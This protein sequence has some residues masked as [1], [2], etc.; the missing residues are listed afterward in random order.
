MSDSFHNAIAGTIHSATG[1]EAQIVNSRSVSGGC[2]SS[3]EIVTLG[4]GRTFFVKSKL[5]A[6]ELF[7]RES[8]G[9][10][11]IERTNA[12]KVPA[13]IGL[14]ETESRVGFLVLEHIEGGGEGKG[15]S[16]TFGRQLAAMHRFNS[17]HGSGPDSFGFEADNFIGSTPQP[18]DWYADWGEFWVENRI[19]FQLK[20]AVEN[21]YASSEFRNGCENLIDKFDQIVAR[22]EC[23]CLIHGDLWS[24]NFMVSSAGSPVLIDP[25]AY[26]GSREA[27]FGMTTL[28]GGFNSHFYHAY[29]EAWP[30]SDGWESRVEIYRLY[31]L[32]NHLNL[33]GSSYYTGCIEIL[34]K[35]L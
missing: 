32:M 18:N 22:D 23:P 21:G 26:F 33:F 31:H 8:E 29:N 16:K 11:A 15:F 12:I 13:V 27:E 30:L 19:R 1:I 3:A 17:E 2:I 10:V 7:Q 25:A 34:R 4:D 9:L 20:L 14:G 28:F 24:G 35:Y 6:G 5:D